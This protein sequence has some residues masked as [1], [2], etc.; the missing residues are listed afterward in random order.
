MASM[1]TA[2]VVGSVLELGFLHVLRRF[3]GQ[4]V[5]EILADRL[6]RWL[7]A[8][9]LSI[10]AAVLMIQGI[11]TVAGFT[12]VINRFISPDIKVIYLLMF[13]VLLAWLGATRSTKTV[14]ILTEI[15]L[16]L[17]VPLVV[18]LLLKSIGGTMMDWDAVMAVANHLPFAPTYK[19]VAAASFVFFG[20]TPLSVMN[21]LLTADMKWRG[22]WILP[23]LGMFTLLASF[24]IPI[25]YHGTEAIENYVYPWTTTS[26][27]LEMEYG[28]IERAIFIFSS[29]Y[30]NLSM[31]YAIVAW[32]VALE[33]FKG[34]FSKKR[35]VNP[36]QTERP[37]L[38]KI[39]CG[40][41]VILAFM[42]V[43]L[44]NE[45]QFFEFGAFV[46]EWNFGIEA[47][48]VALLIYIGWGRKAA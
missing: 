33:W 2:V 19:G 34:G 45:Q 44:L 8:G 41:F 7:C 11:Q 43:K 21:R 37:L 26:D 20:F 36:D 17:N 40:V 15:S 27:S 1:G 12:V 9:L 38:I 32:H 16:L 30:L 10:A 24:F 3:P 18:V 22:L 42:Y 39:I 5:P 14:L 46:H 25:G 4:G 48:L 35:H 29:L 28:L 6:P 47:V 13:T 31:L 23:I